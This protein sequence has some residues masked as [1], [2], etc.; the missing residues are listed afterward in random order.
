MN[1]HQNFYSL[2]D[3]EKNDILDL[4]NDH[5]IMHQLWIG[6]SIAVHQVA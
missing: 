5:R 4:L 3:K 1:V 6:V 2:Y